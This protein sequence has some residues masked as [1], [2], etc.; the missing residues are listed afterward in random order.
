M[1]LVLHVDGDRWRAHLRTTAEARP[2]LVPVAKGNGY[3]LGV[4]R[5]ARKSEWLG[6]DTIAVGTPFEVDDVATRFAGDILVLTPWRAFDAGAV[7]PAHAS[8]VIHTISGPADLDGLLALDPSPRVVLEQMTSMKRHGFTARGLREAVAAVRA[9]P[10]IRLEGASLHLP[11]GPHG[12]NLAEA[13]LLVSDL[14]AAGLG[15]G[16]VWVSHLGVAEVDDLAA[17]YPDIRLRQRIGTE[18]WLGDRA[19]LSVRA[20]V[21]DHHAVER[22]EVFGYRGRTASRGGTI[23]VVSGGTAHGIGLESPIGETS[24]RAR[25]GALARGGL[26]AAGRTRSPFL[27]S[28]KPRYFAEPPHMQSS[29]LFLPSGVAVPE[30]GEAVEVVV[31]HTTTTFD[32]VR[33]S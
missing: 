5:L 27:V 10:E 22:G 6:V 8:R 7:D 20:H 9:R 26:D 1:G 14:V 29:M 17:R 30:I 4:A 19:A 2:G 28:G 18:L 24:V 3:G 16:Q 31:R 12:D 25:A 23:L 21:L 33:I 13:E 15:A 11:L 32:S